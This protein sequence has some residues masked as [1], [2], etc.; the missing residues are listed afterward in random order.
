MRNRWLRKVLRMEY[1]TIEREIYID[2]TPEVVF[3]VVSNP[4]H[5]RQ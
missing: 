4:V 5:V 1:G 3:D 2:A